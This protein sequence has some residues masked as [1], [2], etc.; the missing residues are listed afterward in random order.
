MD[1]IKLSCC[2]LKSFSYE[3][4]LSWKNPR[5]FLMYSFLENE[6]KIHFYKISFFPLN[7]KK[8]QERR[9]QLL[10]DLLK[11]GQVQI[12]KIDLQRDGQHGTNSHTIGTL[13]ILL[14]K[15]LVLQSHK[16]ELQFT[17]TT[18]YMR[19]IYQFYQSWETS[20][21]ISKILAIYITCHI[22]VMTS[23]WNTH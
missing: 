19:Y 7:I 22:G 3:D 6:N 20:A 1:L 11:S 13:R 17:L 18:W 21:S 8:S 15:S 5:T 2:L 16:C 9:I 10:N 14:T 12:L 4:F 23:K